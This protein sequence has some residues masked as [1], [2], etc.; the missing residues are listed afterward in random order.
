MF[1]I[2]QCHTSTPN[3]K[4]SSYKKGGPPLAGSAFFGDG[5]AV[6]GTEGPGLVY[7]LTSDSSSSRLVLDPIAMRLK[8]MSKTV[9]NSARLHTEDIQKG[10]YRFRCAMLTLTYAP[11]AE[12]Q[13]KDIT[14]LLKNIRDYM[15]RK[16][17]SFRY[18]WVLELTKAQ[19]PHYHVLIWLPKGMT[20]PKP[21]KRGWWSLGS[22]RI[23]WVKNPV[24]YI[25]K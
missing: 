11:G 1:S 3:S 23:E 22:T 14:G 16:G 13:A 8:R 20:L 6:K 19:R 12:W 17:Q 15:R 7:S 10:G 5:V 2:Y 9:K 25:A 24:G 18:V 21:D 4:V